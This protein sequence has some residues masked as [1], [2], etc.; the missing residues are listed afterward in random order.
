MSKKKQLYFLRSKIMND[1]EQVTLLLD[2]IVSYKTE[3]LP[4][5]TILASIAHEKSL[6]ISKNNEKIGK[7]LNH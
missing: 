4:E 5:A 1:I 2:Y 3:T 7:I 6:R